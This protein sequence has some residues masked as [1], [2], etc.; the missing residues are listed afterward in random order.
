[1]PERKSE[2]RIV[3]RALVF[4]PAGGRGVS[5]IHSRYGM[6]R[7]EG[8]TLFLN[9]FELLFLYRKAI[10]KPE[11]PLID[12]FGKL[13]DSLIGDDRELDLLRVYSHFRE[14]GFR[15]IR[16]G[17]DLVLVKKGR[18]SSRIRVTVWTEKGK[19]NFNDL[20][21]LPSGFVALLEGT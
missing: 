20:S 10:I 12:D 2:G 8:S 15:V 5:T 13:C 7:L 21:S 19:C 4:K 16:N 9:E 17:N 11:N 6:G 14:K 1:M 18:P 3:C